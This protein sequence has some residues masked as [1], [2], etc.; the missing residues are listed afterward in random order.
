METSP[1]FEFG[2]FRLDTANAQLL[3]DGAAVPLPPKTF[4]VLRLLVSRAGQLVEKD[5]L[6]REVWPDAFVEE[7]NVS[8]HIWTLR[9]ALGDNGSDEQ[10]IQTIPK[11]GYRFAA[12]VVRLAPADIIVTR[13][14]E[15]RIERQE[16]VE[17]E[18][19]AA[20]LPTDPKSAGAGRTLSRSVWVAGALVVAA[21][22]VVSRVIPLATVSPGEMRVAI[23]GVERVFAL[24]PDGRRI[25]YAAEGQLWLRPLDSEEARALSGTGGLRGTAFPFWSPDGESLGFFADNQLKRVD[26]STGLVHG[27]A[28]APNPIGGSWNAEDVIL[29]APSASSPIMRIGLSGGVPAPATSLVGAAHLGH[30]FPSFVDDRHFVFVAAGPADRRGLYLGSLDSQDI[31]RLLETDSGAAVLP[32]DV[33]VFVRNGALVSQRLDVGRH[34]M[35]GDPAPM[36][37]SVLLDPGAFNSVAMSTSAS[38]VLAYSPTA[39]E[40]QLTWVNRKGRTLDDVGSPDYTQPFSRAGLSPD[41]RTLAV[42]R[43]VNGN[44]DIWLVD[45]ARGLPRRLTSDP[46]RDDDGMWSPD[47]QRLIFASERSGIYDIYERRADGAGEEQLVLASERAKRVMDWSRDG[48]FVLYTVQNAAAERDL[49]AIDVDGNRTPI[50]VATTAFEE[51]RGKFSPD[52]QWV[53]YTAD[54]TGRREVYVQRFPSGGR[55][56]VSTDGGQTL[57]WRDDGRELFYLDAMRRAVAVRI[58]IGGDVVHVETP[59]VLFPL[60]PG[61]LFAAAP[62]GQRFLIAREMRAAPPVTLVLN[63]K[64]LS[65]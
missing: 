34:A 51:D 54:D 20:A 63:W 33:L 55:I 64:G 49:W 1:V 48:R 13:T 28:P 12:D 50:P 56:Q 26:L 42:R 21:L 32:G 5:L 7:A 18:P 11:R 45:L 60:P 17:E 61:G 58:D 31:H 37:S 16:L 19:V 15:T 14:T 6:M 40:R 62:D 53:A 22:A 57:Q 35:T 39:N 4:D 59:E 25:V 46:S 47:G 3:R 38:G 9:K 29:F 65:R 24:S 44:T 2:P 10:Y 52:G 8:R 23:P 36:S 27:L 43:V 41:G 30:R